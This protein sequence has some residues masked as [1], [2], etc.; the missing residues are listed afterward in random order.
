MW[1]LERTSAGLA[2]RLT[3]LQ[4]RFEGPR[5]AV[6]QPE[7]QQGA[8]VARPST[9][10]SRPAVRLPAYVGGVIALFPA[11]MLAL[12]LGTQM[13]SAW[14]LPEKYWAGQIDAM[15]HPAVY[16]AGGGLVG[17]LPPMG[18]TDLDATHA[19]DPGLIPAACIELALAREDAHYQSWW[20]Y[21]RGVDLGSVMRATVSAGG[22]S[23]MPMQ[24]SR[25]LAPHWPREH[26]RWVRKLLEVGAASTLVK[27]HRGNHHD[28]ARTYLAVAPFGIAYGDLRGIAAVAD[29][30]WGIPTSHLSPAPCALLIVLLPRRIDF[31]NTESEA[32]RVAWAHRLE[33]A[34]RLLAS[35]PAYAGSVG[36]LTLWAALPRREALVGLPAAA[37]LNLGARTRAVVLPH[38]SRILADQPGSEPDLS[39]ASG[40]A[41][42]A[43]Q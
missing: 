25:Q 29:A 36:E 8:G 9:G 19:A 35:T 16:D 42:K 31:V 3:L 22:A 12:L 6:R 20:R 40:R 43:P 14:V 28:L 1:V 23:T 11:L 30:L 32:A 41:D 10:A 26:H 21:V 18:A 38:R 15:L 37:T 39:V 4:W 2:Q 34:R 27:L 17:F 5:N 24:L 7:A 13:A 33:Q